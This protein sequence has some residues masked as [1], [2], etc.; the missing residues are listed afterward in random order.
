VGVVLTEPI[1]AALSEAAGLDLAH[2]RALH[3]NERIRRALE[4]EQLERVGDLV[5]LVRSDA[6]ARCRFR[7]SVAVSVTGVFR[8]PAQFALL[9]R[10]L[11]PPLLATGRKL[12]VWSAGCS[13]GSELYSVGL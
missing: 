1:P 2:Y 6:S 4:R 11:L 9:E 13:D 12:R 10:H 7:R 3:V 8:D 5:K